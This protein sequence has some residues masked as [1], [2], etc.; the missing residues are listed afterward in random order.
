MPIV[1]IRK[2][3]PNFNQR[4][5]GTVI[6]TIVLHADSAPSVAS[7][8]SWIRDRKS[9][10]SYHYLIG[11]HGDVYECVAPNLR[12]WHAGVSSFRGK[13]NVNDFSIGVSFGNNQKGEAFTEAQYQ[14]GAELCR[15]LMLMYPAI[16]ID[17]I[18]THSAVSP[19]RKLDPDKSPS[20]WDS[21]YFFS[22]VTE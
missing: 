7:S 20:R 13:G 11:R 5:S 8:L 12:A 9:K 4:P 19:G 22:L 6:N 3:S 2:P 14:K 18:T 15:E 17:R 10:V 1:S 16:T 21:A